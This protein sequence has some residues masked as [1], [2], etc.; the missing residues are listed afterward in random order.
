MARKISNLSASYTRLWLVEFL[1]FS[2]YKYRIKLV[3]ILRQR[4][5]Q[6]LISISTIL[7]FSALYPNRFFWPVW[8]R[9]TCFYFFK[10]LIFICFFCKS[11][12]RISC[13]LETMEKFTKKHFLRKKTTLAFFGPDLDFKG[14]VVTHALHSFHGGSLEKTR[15]VP[16]NEPNIPV[17]A[18]IC[19]LGSTPTT[20]RG[21]LT[22]TIS[23]FYFYFLVIQKFSILIWTEQFI[24]EFKFG[25]YMYV[26]ILKLTM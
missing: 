15:T 5:D 4:E 23:W 12:N 24:K 21:S 8:I 14:T 6:A 26:I 1:H 16:L 2:R 25:R 20:A 11:K 9:F 18:S 19:L 10:L 7:K 3:S 22:Y 13:W 17:Q